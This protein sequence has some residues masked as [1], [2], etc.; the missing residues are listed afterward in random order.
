MKYKLSELSNE[1]LLDLIIIISSVNG[2]M[3]AD[4]VCNNIWLN[5]MNS[6]VIENNSQRPIEVMQ[7]L[8]KFMHYDSWTQLSFYWKDYSEHHCIFTKE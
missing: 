6:L 5:E 4:R 7:L 2:S 1:K 8:K 3:V